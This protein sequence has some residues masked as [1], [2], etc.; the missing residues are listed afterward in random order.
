MKSVLPLAILAA[1]GLGVWASG[2]TEYLGWHELARHQA[3]L[4]GHQMDI[5]GSHSTKPHECDT[6]SVTIPK[7]AIAPD[8]MKSLLAPQL[9]QGPSQQWK[10]GASSTWA[11]R[12][13]FNDHGGRGY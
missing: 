1:L 10:N 12:N 9:E 4:L 3:S 11:N 13:H 8:A 6:F 7:Y 5:C 2:L